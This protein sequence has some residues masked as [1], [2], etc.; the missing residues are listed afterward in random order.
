MNS[1]RTS[2]NSKLKQ[3]RLLKTEIYE[4]KNTA[5]DRKDELK[6]GKP[7]LKKSNRNPGNKNFLDQI[8]KY[9][10]KPVQQSTSG[11]QKGSKKK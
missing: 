3:R 1:K 4:I 6:Y 8:K 10:G 2:T 7:Q 11:R 5:Q 9:S